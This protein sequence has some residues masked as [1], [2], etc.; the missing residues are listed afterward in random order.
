MTAG[1]EYL[2]ELRG[3]HK[4]YGDVEV[5]KDVGLGLADGEFVTILGPSGSGKTTIL[6]MIGGFIDPSAG[7]ILFEGRN[8]VGVPIFR[9]PFNTVFQDYALFPHMTVAQNVAYGLKVKG[10]P[11]SEVKRR[12]A[13]GLRQV[14]LEEFMKRYPNQLSGGQR[15]RVA[16]CRALVCAPRVLLLDEPLGALDAEFRRQMQVFLKRLQREIKTTFLFV[17]HDQEEAITI[18]DRICVMSDGLIEQIGPPT[19]LYYRPHSEFVAGFFGDNNLIAGRLGAADGGQR[20][21]ET[22]LGLIR[23]GLEGLPHAAAANAG[24]AVK[25]AVRPETIRIGDAQLAT[26]NRMAVNVEEVSFVGPT[27]HVIVRAT[28]DP[29]QSL[30]IKQ[31][32]EVAGN[33]L[34]PGAAA[35]IGWNAAECSIVLV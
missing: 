8:I 14:S 7:E 33:S 20:E 2:L 29:R 15:Q 12:V 17:T 19:E 31:P 10:V 6:R 35:H 26:E 3:V 13:E 11:R 16:L 34:E 1:S 22:E 32:S 5:L 21:V 27:S 28:A 24:Q 18:S 25:L 23:F 4:S 9:R 30:M